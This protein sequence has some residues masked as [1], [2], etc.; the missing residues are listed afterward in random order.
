M[1]KSNE[2]LIHEAAME[3]LQDVGVK[4]H[5]ERAREILKKNGIRVE[6]EIAYFTEEQVMHWVKMAPSTFTL[7]AANPAY[8]MYF[9]TDKSYAAP[10]YGCAFMADR[11]GNK[12]PGVMKDYVELLKLIQASDVYNINGG[13]MVQPSDV[14][15]KNAPLYMLYATLLHSDKAIM[16]STA[17]GD[18][19]RAM[20]EAGAAVFGGKEEFAKKPRMI[21][22]INTNSP[23]SLDEK[24]LDNLMLMAEYGQPAIV[25]PAA[26]LGATGPLPMAGTLA[27]GTAEDLA[28]IALMQM[29]R[30]GAPSVFGI[31]ST[32]VD[33]MGVTF[34]CAAPEG[35]IMQGYAA[36]LGKFYGLPSRGG[37]S[38]TDALNLN[39]Q[40]GYES[41][42]TF[43]SATKAGLNIIME[44]GGIVDSVN[45]TCVE[46][47]LCD[48][49]IIRLV[50]KATEPLVVNE[51]TLCMD[52]I[53]EQAHVGG[54]LTSEYTL[55]NFME[56][57]MPRV[58]LR[59]GKSPEYL[60][61]TLEK[62]YNRLMDVYASTA[63]RRDEEEKKA[64]R[65]IFIKV[66]APEEELIAVENVQ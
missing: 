12:R 63:P 25:C 54:F 60:D 31:Q 22:L 53:K 48:M 5:N 40:A 14:S 13:I 17:D 27:S 11:D 44:A 52:D 10:A 66:G 16:L 58:G 20:L 2:Q 59:E 51:E 29:V 6:R 65:D 49:E 26:M 18:V 43:F 56:L 64:L 3:I 38:Q 35:T 41:M 36:K 21:T 32:A 46:K 61:E 39:I 37:G 19:M 47:L 24:M 33:M 23:L 1:V 34:A 8:N 55:D 30:P 45:A 42:L 50:K 57:Y 28:G 7:H 15:E 62:E 4:F 9:G